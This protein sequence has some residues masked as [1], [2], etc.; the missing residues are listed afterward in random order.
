MVVQATG[1]AL[2]SKHRDTRCG[3]LDR[4]LPPHREEGDESEQDRSHATRGRLEAWCRARPMR[5]S[6]SCGVLEPYM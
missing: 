6:Q 1:K 4:L 3:E 5:S 2:D